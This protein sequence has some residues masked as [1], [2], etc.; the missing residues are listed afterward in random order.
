VAG[1]IS[2]RDLD[3]ADRQRELLLF[4][5]EAWAHR[6]R[7]PTFDEIAE[8]RQMNKS[9]VHRAV[10]ILIAKDYLRCDRTRT[11][12]V[13]TGTVEP[14]DKAR[15]WRSRAREGDLPPGGPVGA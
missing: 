3:D 7:V 2:D 13:R 8:A 9:G 15:R 12:R 6:H 1:N 4:I 5:M 14:T 10:R 11:G